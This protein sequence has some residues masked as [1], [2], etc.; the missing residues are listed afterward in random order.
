VIRAAVFDMDGTLISS[1]EIWDEVREGLT[2]ET[3]G[4]WA[5]GAHEA[6][7]G[8]STPEWTAYMRDV[9]GVPMTREEI[10]AETVRRLLA[11][12]RAEPPFLPGAIDAVRR[13]AALVPLGL[14]SSSTRELIAGVLEMAGIAAL[15]EATASSEEVG[16]GKPAPDVYLLALR[17]MG[18]EG[19]LGRGDRGHR[20]G[21]ALGPR[22]RYAGGGRAE[23]PVPARRGRPRGGRRRA[24]AHR[25]ARRGR[26]RA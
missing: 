15:F 21:P 16:R 26:A 6:M 23:R 2:R 17:R 13:A 3:G 8:L 20:R 25:P 1:E 22:R 12:Y 18:V 24:G 14:A 4:R 11:R 9:L 10:A 19:G 5:L 7:M